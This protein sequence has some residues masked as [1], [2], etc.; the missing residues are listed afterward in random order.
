MEISPLHVDASPTTLSSGYVTESDA[1]EDLGEDLKEDLKEDLNE[2]LA[3][4]PAVGGDDDDEEEEEDSEEEDEKEEH[5]APVDSTTLPAIDHVP[6]V[7]DTEVF[8]INESALTPPSP[9][10]HTSLTYA[11]APLDYKAA[12]IRSR[13]ASPPPAL[14]VVVA[15]AL[16]LSSPPPSPLTPLSSPLPYIPSPPL[17]LPSPPLPLLAPS[18]PLLLPA[19]DRREDV[20]KADVPPRKRLC[21]TAPALRFEVGESSAAVVARYPGL[22]VTHATDYSFV[23]IVDA[24][25]RR[26]MSR[27]QG[28]DKTKEPELARDPEPQDG[29]ANVGSC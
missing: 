6:S 26:P 19:T 27:E 10:T 13:A 15:I 12:M 25:P 28:H 5:Q 1:E 24:T 9:P 8:E 16:P 22:D 4:Y 17:P 23:D 20:P 11:D 7:K 29:P 3:D 21:L 2:D 14:I 18:L